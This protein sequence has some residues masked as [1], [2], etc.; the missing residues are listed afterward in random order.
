MKRWILA[1]LI[2]A[3]AGGAWAQALKSL[4]NFMHDARSGQARF[5]QKVTAPPRDGQ[6]AAPKVSSGSFSFERL[7]RFRFDYEKPFVQTIVADG[8]TLWLFDADLNQVT[9]RAQAQALGSTP[10]ALLTSRPD[11]A[12]L[13]K[14]F[15]LSE[16]PDAD[17]LHWVLALP[18][19]KDGQLASVRIGLD[20]DRLARLDITDHFGQRS[21]LTFTDFKLNPSLPPETFRFTPPKGADVLR[22][23]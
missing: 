5:T 8:T 9:E 20:G 6:A 12:A 21:Q 7:G 22:E 3:C 16:A 2:A 17:G 13:G 19:A 11:L 18:R 1:L 14:D 4:E 23:P 10:A 15:T